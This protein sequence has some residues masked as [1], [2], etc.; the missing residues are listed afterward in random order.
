[1]RVTSRRS[2]LLIGVLAAALAGSGCGTRVEDSA[3]PAVGS[4][5]V[6]T[7]QNAA[8]TGVANV[9]PAPSGAGGVRPATANAAPSAAAGAAVQTPA[10]EK[11]SMPGA[12]VR[13]TAPG[14]PAQ[15]SA[16][17]SGGTTATS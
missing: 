8:S 4:A 3:V 12:V 16:A 7:P 14:A 6:A 15:V 11:A 13:T 5:A 17:G 10:A 2:G 9:D 1:M